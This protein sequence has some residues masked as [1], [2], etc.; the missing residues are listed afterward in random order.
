MLIEL[1]TWSLILNLLN[2][3][4]QWQIC[5]AA[6]R[7]DFPTWPEGRMR[8]RNNIVIGLTLAGLVESQTTVTFWSCGLTVPSVLHFGSHQHNQQ[9]AKKPLEH[10]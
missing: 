10:K 8:V 2:L 1:W 5:S 3:V 4:H 7:H 9:M 6:A